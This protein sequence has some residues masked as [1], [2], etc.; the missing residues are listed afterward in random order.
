MIYSTH[1][2]LKSVG[3]LDF[4][5]SLR[6]VALLL[7]AVSP[8]FP[9]VILLRSQAHVAVDML[10]TTLKVCGTFK[11]TYFDYK[12]T[13]NAECPNN[14][15]RVQNNALF[16]RLDSFL[17]RCHDILDLAQTIV[18]FDKL[19][20]IE[21]GGTKGKTLTTNVQQI[22]ADFEQAVK[23]FKNVGYD[24]ME[25]SIKQ[26]DDD[27]YEFRCSIKELERRLG[28][29]L[30]TA[31]DD[32]PTIT[33]RFKLLDLFEGLLDRTIIQDELEK[34]HS[35]LVQTYGTDL[36]AV[37]ELFLEF[38]DAPPIAT[39]LPPIAGAISWC[40]GITERITLP[41]ENLQNFHKAVMEREET[42]EVSKIYANIMTSLTEYT[43]VK[44]EEWGRDVESSSQAKL[45]LPLLRRDDETRLLSVN[46]DKDLDKLLREVK[47]FLI[48]GLAVPDSALQ[49]YKK[50]EVF[51]QQTGNLTLIVNMYNDM[52][53]SLLPVEVPLVKVHFD[54][55]DKTVARG[56]NQMNWKSHGIDFFITESMACVKVA[57][58]ILMTL[59]SNLDEVEEK[60]KFWA[61]E[62][63]I[64]RTNRPVSPEE[65]DQE[66]KTYRHARYPEITHGG[67]DIHSL[68]K[69]S[70]RVLKVSQGLPDWKAYVDFVNNMVLDGLARVVVVSLEF[71]HGQIAPGAAGQEKVPMMEISLDLCGDDVMFIPDLFETTQKN[72]VRDIVNGWIRDFFQVCSLFKRVDT[73][74][75]SYTKEI[76]SN[77]D[78]CARLAMINEDLS[79]N[80]EACIAF[81]QKYKEYAYLWTTDLQVEFRKFLDDATLSTSQSGKPN[82][83][84][85]KFD[86]AISKYRELQRQVNELRTPADI[87]WLRVNS[88]PIKQAMGTWVTKWVFMYT[89]YLHDMVEIR[90]GELHQFIEH[91]SVGLDVEVAEGDNEALMVAMGHVRDVRKSMDETAAMFEPIRRTVAL[92]K[93]HGITFADMEIG[94]G[95]VMEFLEHVPLRWDALV[96]KTFKKKEEILPFQNAEVDNIKE[97]LEQFFLA[98]REFRAN[99]RANAPFDHPGPKSVIYA[100]LD[101]FEKA[102]NDKVDEAA[103]LN[104]LEELFELPVSK[105]NEPLE[106]LEEMKVLKQT[107]DYNDMIDST[108]SN[109]SSQ[110]W[111]DIDTDLLTE[112]NATLL[113][114]LRQFGQQN[115]M[116]KGWP[117]YKKMEQ[118]VKD[119]SAVLP[120]INDLHAK[121]MQPRHWK[122]LSMICQANSIDPRDPKL[123]LLD[124]LSLNLHLHVDDVTEIV[125]TAKKELKVENQLKTIEQAWTSL[126]LEYVQHKDT[127]VFTLKT[128][129]MVVESLELHQLELQT[130][131]S[132][133]KFVDYFRDRV[134]SWQKTL[135]NVET[136]LKD[137]SSVTKQWASLESIFLGS[138]DIRSQL[139]E[140]TK[141]FEGIDQE[142]KDLMKE[143]AGMPNVIEATTMEGREEL[144][145]GMM[146]NLEL[147]QKSLNEYLDMKKTIFP[148][149]Y[150]ISNPAL[151]EILSNGNNPPKIMNYVS[152]CYVDGIKTL[153]F[154][155][156]EKGEVIKNTAVAMIAKD[157]ERINFKHTNSDNGEFVMDGAVE[158]WLT[159]LT[160]QMT[161]TLRDSLFS[162]METAMHW[163]QTNPRHVWLR[164]YPAQTVLNCTQIFWSEET[165]HALDDLEAGNEDALIDYLAICNKRL[166]N[167][168]NLV[169]GELARALRTTVIAL[170]TLDVH[171][172]DCIQGL[173]DERV[174]GPSAFSWQKQLR[175]YPGSEDKKDVHIRITD[176]KTLYSYE[177]IGNRTRLVITPLTDRCYVTLCTAMKLMLGAAPA[178]PAGTGKTETTKD[179]ARAMAR[180]IYV[181][182]CSDQ[183]NFQ[184]LGDLFRGLAQAGAW[185]C[186]D[187]FNRI[188][189]E[190]LSVVATQ[191]KT[192]LDAMSF[193]SVPSNR[194]EKYQEEPAGCPPVKVGN[195]DFMGASIGLIP[196]TANF[197]TMN[198]GYAGRTE[199]P[200]NVKALFRWCAMIR[201]DLRIIMENMMM[202]EGFLNA[203]QLSIKFHTLYTLSKDLLSKQA[204][205]D[206][207]LRAA[208][209]VL[210]YAGDL[211]RRSV[212]MEEEPILM[213]ALRDFNTPKIPAQDIPIFLR[214]IRDLFPD[215]ADTTPPIVD[216]RLQRLTVQACE[217]FNL[218]PEEEFVIKVGQYAEL[219]DVRHSVMLLGPAGCGK[220][221]IWKML[222]AAFNIEATSKGEKRCAV[223]ETA[224]PKA[225]TTDELYGY[226]TLAKDWKDGLLSI[227]MRGMSKNYRDQGFYESQTSK[228]VVLD[229]DIDAVWIE[230][231]NTV[232]DDNKVLTLVSN[233][234]IPLTPAMRMI[235]EVNSLDNA[236]PATVSRAGILY[237]NETDIGWR[238]MVDSWIQLRKDEMERTILTDLFN[239]YI[240]TVQTNTE[241]METVVP[242]RIISKVET[243]IGLM[244]SLLAG[245]AL[246]DKEDKEAYYSIAEHFMVF[247]CVWAFGGPLAYK[248]G[249]N[250]RSDFNK[251]WQMNFRECKFP[252][253]S[254]VFGCFYDADKKSWVSWATQ[255]E[256]YIPVP[257]GDQPGE[258]PFMNLTVQSSDFVA[259]NYVV[260]KLALQGQAAML[261]GGAGTGKTTIARDFIQRLDEDTQHSII[262]LSYYTDS[263]A[264]QGELQGPVEKRSGKIFGPPPG[265]K[266]VYFLD[267]LNLPYIEEYGTQNA[268]SL[269]TQH[270]NYGQIYDRSD[271]SLKKEIVDVQYIAAMNPNSGSFTICERLQRHFSVV[272]CMMPSAGDLDVIFSAI[273]DGHVSTF[274]NEVQR[275]V[276]NIVKVSIQLHEAIQMKF[277][278]SAEKFM[279]NWNMRELGNIFQGMCLAR[280]EFYP[281][282]LT[283]ARLWIHECSRVFRDRMINETDMDRFDT[284][285]VQHSKSAFD[286]EQDALNLQPN[287]FTNFATSGGAQGPVYLPIES[288]EALAGVLN[289]KLLEYNE[290]NTIMN[291]VLFHQAMEHVCRITRIIQNPSGNA[292]LIGVGG[293][294]KQSLCRLASFI[295][296][297]EVR[298]LSVTSKYTV[299]DLKE[300]LRELYQRAG[301]KGIQ[302]TFMMTD[303]QI[304]NEKF[305]V[306]VNG[307]LTSGWIP[308]LFTKDD[309]EGIFGALRSE[310]KANAIAATPETMTAFFISRVRANLHTVLCFSPKGD[311]FRRRSVRFPGLI[312]CTSIDYFHPWSRDALVSVADNFLADV[313]LGTQDTKENVAHHMAE[314]H[315]TVDAASAEY[316]DRRRRYNYVT[317]KSFLELINFYKTLL[318]GHRE[319][320]G[321]LI[322][323]LDTG[324][325][326][327]RKTQQDVAELQVDLKHTLAKVDEKKKATDALLENMGNQRGEAE[328]EQKAADAEREK[329]ET[330]LAES[331]LIEKSADEELKAA[332]P[333]MEAAAEAVRVLDKRMLGELAGLTTPPNG[334]PLVTTAVM[335]MLDGEFKNHKWDRARKMMKDTN[336]FLER[337]EN[338]DM[339]SMDD[340]LIKHLE[341]IVNDEIMT[342]ET[343]MKKSQAAGNLCTWVQAAYKYNRIWVRVKPLMDTLDESR[344]KSRIATE[345]AAAALAKV[346]KVNAAL[347]ELQRSFMAATEDKAKVEAEAAACQ[348]RLD[349]AN[350]LVN[351]LSSENDRWGRDVEQLRTDESMLVGDVLLA[352]S[353][354][355]YIGAFDAEF[356]TKL[357]HDTWLPDLVS[358]EIPI[359]DEI[360]PMG[361]LSTDSAEA[362]MCGQGLPTDRISVENGTIVS[363]CKRWPL[364]IDPQV[365]AIKWLRERYSDATKT[366]L[367]IMQL[368]HPNWIRTLSNSITMGETVIIENLG[369]D[370]DATLEPVLAQSLT[371]RGRNLY[372]KFGGEE[373]EYDEKFQLFLLTR[374]SNP[375]YKPEIAAQCTLIN[376]IATQS[377][378]EDQ[379][380]AKVVNREKP[381]LEQEK[382]DLIK[383][384]NDYKIQLVELEDQLLQRLANAPE[385]I[386][387]DVPLIEGLEA[388]KKASM[389]INEAVERGKVT[390]VAINEAREVFRPAA[391][392]AA[393]LYFLV[394]Q[395]HAIDHMYQYSLDAFSKFF[396]KALE[397]AVPSAEAHQ[398]VKSLK[399]SLRATIYAWVSRG[400][401][402]KHKLLFL[403]QLAFNLMRRG[404]L[405]EPFN[406]PY[407][408]FLIRG[409]KKL[410][411]ESPLPWMPQSAWE[412]LC[413]LGELDGFESL[414]DNI[415]ETSN[416]FK[417][418]YNHTTPEKEKLPLDWGALDKT[419]FLKLLV[420]RCLRPDRL[421]ISLEMW[422]RQSMPDGSWFADC[423]ST[424]NAY[425]IVEQSLADSSPQ[426]PIY[427]ILSPGA[428]V[429]ADVDRAATQRGLEKG[430]SYHNI[431]MGQGQDVIAMNVLDLAHRQGQWVIL[432]NVHLMPTWLLDVEKILDGYAVEGSH[433]NFRLFLTSDPSTTIPIGILARCIKLT[434]EPPAGLKAN[435]QRAFSSLNKTMFEDADDKMKSIL[436]GLCQFHSIMLERRRF[437]AKGFNMNYPFSLGDLRDSSIC[438]QNYM[439]SSQAAG[440]GKIPW[441]DLQYIFGQIMYGGH[442]VNDNDRLLAMTY[443]E[444][445]MRDEL[446]DEMEMYPFVEEEKGAS[447]K[448]PAATSYDM[449]LEYIEENL[450]ETSPVA[451]GLHPNAEIDFRAEQSLGLF[452][453]LK[454]MQPREASTHDAALSP[455]HQT[456]NTL[457]DI[458]DRF[459]DVRFEIGDIE[460]VIEDKGPY[461]NVFI[462]EC[463]WFNRLLAHVAR[464]LMELNEGLGGK[465]TIT[466]DMEKLSDDLYLEKV[467]AAWTKLA[468]P[469]KRSLPMWLD[470]MQRR[471]VQ[472]QDWAMNPNEISKVVWISGLVNAQSFLTAIKQVTAQR[473]GAELDQLVIQTDVQKRK[474][475]D[476]EQNSRDGVFV[477]GLF[478]QG[479]SWD[480]PS[481][482]LER[483]KPKEMFYEMP[484]I[485]CRSIE[486][487]NMQLDGFYQCPVYMTEQRGPTYVFDAQLKTKSPAARWI[488][489]GVA[490]VMDVA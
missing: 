441:A 202:S 112:G 469:S 418:W 194:E 265:K 375:H 160:D 300:E 462:Q 7:T 111:T 478:L 233:E 11:S 57:N 173:A 238:P 146:R 373:I 34:K 316:F 444:F 440:G 414:P 243:V 170:I 457:N 133:G 346:E 454:E 263:E 68:L 285:M 296:G 319:T 75:G 124:L 117:V 374:L 161:L 476:V 60:L 58:D 376:F 114:T 292:M 477:C 258:T 197:I 324:L 219:L 214:L 307:I 156:N 99:F 287:I 65:F 232:M 386:L 249:H 254:S 196:T 29:V 35:A 389:E 51:R 88:Q 423:D 275:L 212:G 241:K 323:R 463:E 365:Q 408:N 155:K 343:M 53:T 338:Y 321:A 23:T 464:S 427:F 407:F 54:R 289:T 257:I 298:Q 125:E 383:S 435:M 30:T 152:D 403:S 151:L 437:G 237:I 167:L 301:V 94:S 405:A 425:D 213:R 286:L 377:G 413:A 483:S 158:R 32:S 25:V 456:E 443:L 470:N 484:V 140:D 480:L 223:Y 62:P 473:V 331:T 192:I 472:L 47:Y 339:Q 475:E 288:T 445:Y 387:S 460:V 417:S 179:L 56:V 340:D 82:V 72:G 85:G 145:K 172:R 350:R 372:V 135:G 218:Q 381:E 459:G 438:L 402:Q 468:W 147:C 122:A 451:F 121:S 308:D 280:A 46:F 322:E 409:T 116:A 166:D 17:E 39:N 113:K 201:P 220:S 474:L 426:T 247:S 143:A 271:L 177:W 193:F 1:A 144:L 183:M 129:D 269:L 276:P 3:D 404:E 481:G 447:F 422:V 304:V 327:L 291:L 349:L 97:Q 290:S 453:T 299:E 188:P 342:T 63:L 351:G 467:P 236:S 400:L 165:E 189:I 380:L 326:T 411:Q 86:A 199:L 90:L 398:R 149:F 215:Y 465:L 388:T 13:A 253:D 277:L 132:L 134:T 139:P 138:A 448:A 312:N 12:A 10:K 344:E 191:V 186:F 95:T 18:Q 102:R 221:T 250:W 40:R 379:L 83:D 16:M 224:N 358:R 181:F 31:F 242:V 311:S 325:A 208:K 171:A 341:P 310:A 175:F 355:S 488:M 260:T 282:G 302:T 395:L 78:V 393:M 128:P 479:A 353:F 185:G 439:E 227:I 210:V 187:E 184:S 364:L 313:D 335:M 305:L 118:K 382:Q 246:E 2:R 268:H 59:K 207:A 367:R 76:L 320:S 279:Y 369:S 399:K 490:L 485:N 174:E 22:Y 101:K 109:W 270:L 384:F 429:V 123:S 450:G 352:A 330:A 19:A 252:K 142:F 226:M 64:R 419:P 487:R 107:W 318:A 244:K 397:K 278:P 366:T 70:N 27:F 43:T 126:Q 127:D 176:Y 416:R 273:L 283:F 93:P 67:K 198:P 371:K 392:E 442:I 420:T 449:Y 115:N 428:D 137:W 363:L 255:V 69:D 206:W 303:S 119:M 74:G 153:V 37:Q 38:R 295:C 396:N 334:V 385:D 248:K 157:G 33:G 89:Q 332:T 267:D 329:A 471:M 235:F 394:T 169:T 45:K 42:K 281:S 92:L 96:N 315:L 41:M 136:V 256:E 401:F 159:D 390:E 15:W 205:Y 26:F 163:E 222:A 49:I 234:R 162:G 430:L 87:G 228:W 14:P 415:V 229:G 50:F 105:Y 141:R 106:T 362:V 391:S 410:N 150:F 104:E 266:H 309:M 333:A 204:H 120:L 347:D 209:S 432:N 73:G 293:S 195:F 306:Y 482:N 486:V 348:G 272:S 284:L 466:E 148:R 297:Y 359:S 337:L 164:D 368:S 79:T 6:F 317:P 103:R 5:H 336:R 345:S 154:K 20:K 354:V 216:E 230:S 446:L 182:N 431:S 434:N 36:K 180:I 239:K 274:S 261:V 356:R 424:L 178:G 131:I 110:T 225:V 91:T 84:L 461:Q 21:I 455:Q 190:V 231:M 314:V 433:E 360:D 98:M 361:I 8:P 203:R 80:E 436:F 108:Y 66:H 245:V 211:K 452:D 100:M 406:Y 71:L 168:I 294:G 48:L 240:D 9:V 4:D 458:I 421:T 28:S 217:Q 251:Y 370:I 44:I 77:M 489:A 55:I 259:M 328:I 52:I 357:W 130:M 412:M 61:R 264:L 262:N 24:I 81:E 378:L 200:E